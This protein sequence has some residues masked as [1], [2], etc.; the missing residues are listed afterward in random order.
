MVIICAVMGSPNCEGSVAVGAA[1]VGAMT[2]IRRCPLLAETSRKIE[3]GFKARETGMSAGAP[4]GTPIWDN[5]RVPRIHLNRFAVAAD[6]ID[7]N[8]HVGNLAYPG[9]MQDA[10]TA[11]SAA[12]GWTLERYRALGAGWFVRSH[13]I[14]YLRPAFAGDT[15]LLY[16][17][18]KGMR[19]RSSPRRYLFRRESDG[20][21]VAEAET[22]WVF[23]DY[24]SGRLVRIAPDVVSAFPIVP[25][26]DPELVALM[27][28]P[29]RRA[30][31]GR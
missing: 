7:G 4:N 9:W 5:C 23:V 30:G 2:N 16:T 13:F 20:V 1:P 15:L 26:D 12:Q 18:V 27:G 14:E 31:E 17:W 19:G 22:L 24:G 10:A 3:A 6:A 8:G 25:D 28:R 29:T 21:A 11:H